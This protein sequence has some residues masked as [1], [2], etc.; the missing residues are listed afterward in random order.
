VLVSALLIC[1]AGCTPEL[2]GYKRIRISDQHISDEIR[3]S[4]V[5]QGFTREQVIQQL[6]EPDGGFYPIST[7]G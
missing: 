2:Y 6:G 3:K 4:I 7:D 1:A 5:E